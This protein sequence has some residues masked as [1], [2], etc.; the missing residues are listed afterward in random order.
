MPSNDTL[1]S[2]LVLLMVNAR[3]TRPDEK[4]PRCPFTL[5]ALIHGSKMSTFH[6]SHFLPKCFEDPKW[7]AFHLGDN[8]DNIFPTTE[9]IHKNME[10]YQNVPN[11]TICFSRG[12]NDEFDEYTIVFN[13]QLPFLHELRESLGINGN[14][15]K[16]ILLAKHSR[17][18]CELHHKVFQEHHK[19]IP[20]TISC[21]D[22]LVSQK[23]F[24]EIMLRSPALAEM[25]KKVRSKQPSTSIYE[26]SVEKNPRKSFPQMGFAPEAAKG[27]VDTVVEVSSKLFSGWEVEERVM[28]AWIKS[29][30][31]RARTFEV[32]FRPNVSMALSAED[33]KRGFPDDPDREMWRLSEASILAFGLP[34]SIGHLPR[35]AIAGNLCVAKQLPTTRRRK[36]KMAAPAEDV[37]EGE[38]CGAPPGNVAPPPQT[39]ITSTLLNAGASEIKTTDMAQEVTGKWDCT[40]CNIV[41]TAL[42]THCTKCKLAYREV[43]I[44]SKRKSSRPSYIEGKRSCSKF[45]LSKR[46]EHESMHDGT[47]FPRSPDFASNN[48]DDYCKEPGEIISVVEDADFDTIDA[49][50]D[51]GGVTGNKPCGEDHSR[52]EH[53]L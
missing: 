11:L 47:L 5:K 50:S 18:F 38:A 27:L 10:L 9:L 3:Y 51:G 28:S 20:P 36:R 14:Q 8:A 49:D 23:L 24:S 29:H 6:Y 44:R 17:P 2:Y 34:S 37:A 48:L 16:H 26:L 32:A 35:R 45:S 1:P 4:D 53:Q 40:R 31:S 15:Q 25:K 41:N 13:A 39:T 21:F 22:R 46:P 33:F 52:Q 42:Q 19:P 43:G 7:C 12:Y 30:G